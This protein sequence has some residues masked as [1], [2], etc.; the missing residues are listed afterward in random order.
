MGRGARGDRGSVTRRT[1]VTG[2][3]GFVGSHLARALVE[4]GDRVTVIDNAR[5]APGRSGLEL[6]GIASEVELLTADLSEPG[7]VAGLLDSGAGFDSIFHLAA[8]TLVGPAMHD[9][10]ATFEANVKGTW[11]LLE[12]CR[13]A[14]Q[15]KVIMASSDKAYGPSP[16]LPYSEPQALVPASPYESSKAAA[17]MIAR[18]YAGSYA[19]PVAVTRFANIFGGGDLNFSRLIPE[20][21]SAVVQDRPPQIRSD[22]SPERDYL[23]VA[24]AVDAYL[25]IEALLDQGHKGQLDES[26]DSYRVFNAGSGTPHSVR[27]L[28]ASLAEAIEQ[29]IQADY[30]GVGVPEGEIDRQ[31]VDSRR[32]REATGW[33]PRTGL[34]EGLRLTY[35]WYADHA[36]L[37]AAA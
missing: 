21:V 29:P 13:V 31:W 11:H 8:Q 7:Q 35:E 16:Q 5:P 28:I 26:A 12:A 3:Q 6:Q 23:Y 33:G 24:D 19:M 27:G 34:S 17:E 9:P 10:V 37:F 4:R 22:G 1:L 30:R 20:L 25:A 32:L 14:G 2:G 15:A 36:E 18:A